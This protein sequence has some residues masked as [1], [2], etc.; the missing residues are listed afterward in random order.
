MS[1]QMFF[2][3]TSI[4]TLPAT[5]LALWIADRIKPIDVSM[6]RRALLVI[7]SYVITLPLVVVSALFY[8]IVFIIDWLLIRWI[9]VDTWPG[10][11]IR[12]LLWY[13]FGIVFGI[14]IGILLVFVAVVFSIPLPGL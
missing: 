4:L 14:V 11:A 10:A 5:Y 9:Y 1:E 8:P 3:A 12:T 2:I 13:A 7:L 6:R